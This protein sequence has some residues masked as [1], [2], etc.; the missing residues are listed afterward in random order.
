MSLE[1]N[2]L[3]G[4]HIQ[5]VSTKLS[6]D[7]RGKRPSLEMSPCPLGL[8]DSDQD[9]ADSRGFDKDGVSNH[10]TSPVV[11]LLDQR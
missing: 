10:E 6:F 1:R 7:Q 4:N 2:W 5:P 9:Q 8:R 11:V 3:E